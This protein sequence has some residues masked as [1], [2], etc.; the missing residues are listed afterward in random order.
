MPIILTMEA[1]PTPAPSRSL[2]RSSLDTDT[3]AVLGQLPMALVAVDDE[4]VP[5]WWND[6]ALTLLGDDLGD[7]TLSALE[8]RVL[9]Q[10][11]RLRA[12]SAAGTAP[13]GSPFTWLAVTERD[14]DADVLEAFAHQALHDHLTGLPNRTLLNDRLQVALDGV[15]RSG[16]GVAVAFLDLDHF[17]LTNDTQGHAEGDE[18]LR[19][20]AER[21]RESVRPG[22]TV[23]RFGG[24]EFVVVC[25]GVA[26][27]AEA[28][29]LA[30]RLR[31]SIEA[32]LTL[33]GEEVFVSAS[34]GIAMGTS[35]DSPE[36]LLR[37]A[38]AAMYQAKLEGRARTKM[39]DHAIRWRAELRRETERALRTALDKGQFELAYQPIVSLD[40][41]W[42]VGAEALVRWRHPERGIVM[43]DEFIAVAEETSLILPLGEWVLDEACRQLRQWRVEVP[44]VPLFM[45]VNIS[46]RQLRSSLIEVV[47]RATSTHCVDSASLTL[48]IT[49][50]VLMEDLGRCQAALAELK[51]FGV[52]VAI[53]D[54]GVGYS[55]LNYLKHLPIDIIKV[56]RG[57]VDGLGT[58]PNDSAIVSAILGMARALKVSAVAEGVESA[59][60]LYALRHLGCQ[61]AQG[62]RFSPAVP[63]EEFAALL[64]QGNRW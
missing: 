32:P 5:F 8:A 34:L 45:S 62:F 31:A 39:F 13:D 9:E 36:A 64:A 56:D 15:K 52:H 47:R 63:P 46:G 41:G 55:S 18:L 44:N 50:G 3:M 29:E 58:D 27:Y 51:A 48:E 12:R 53:D 11:Q 20:V 22:D 35:D 19:V 28:M 25:E 7:S 30:E 61:L 37:D 14:S 21:L 33:R 38:D 42:V 10:P 17:K 57:F 26:G 23:A 24:D 49:E 16:L 54:F 43:P 40:A 4:G 1:S 59:E 2:A 60:Q 6:E